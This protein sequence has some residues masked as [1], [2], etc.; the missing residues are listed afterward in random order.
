MSGGRVI[1][2]LE[3]DLLS[4]VKA[5]ASRLG[6]STSKV[7]QFAWL[8]AKKQLAAAASLTETDL[9]SCGIDTNAVVG[10]MIGVGWELVPDRYSSTLKKRNV[11]VSLQKDT[12]P[13]VLETVAR[14]QRRSLRDLL[15]DVVNDKSDREDTLVTRRSE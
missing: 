6:W 14:V 5:E 12:L 4:E 8:I 2:S 3:S 13:Q 10:Y 7:V 1:V 15:R 11:T 9:E